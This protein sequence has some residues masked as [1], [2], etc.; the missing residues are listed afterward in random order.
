MKTP[1]IL[2]ILVV[3]LGV[4]QT[5]CDGVSTRS[6]K[7]KDYFEGE[8]QIQFVEAVAKGDETRMRELL[9]QGAD[10]NAV[11]VEEIHPLFWA[12]A[13]RSLKGF[14]FLLKNG[15]DPNYSTGNVEDKESFFSAMELAAS[16]DNSDYLLL[17][18][19][20]GGN[21]NL[22]I[23]NGTRSLINQ[24]VIYNQTE[25]VRLL[26]EA[27]ADM[28]HEDFSGKTPM[29]TAA[30]FNNYEIVYLFLEKG[31]DPTI[32]S[33]WGNDLSGQIKLIADRAM[34]FKQYKWY[35]MVVNELKSRG[36]LESNWNPIQHA[37]QEE[38]NKMR[39]Q[40]LVP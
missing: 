1:N 14:E 27:G 18:L 3:G 17:L 19:E 20:Y 33:R 21:P 9:K 12:M 37:T 24:A 7:A 28:D 23:G 30:N 36:L 26:I 16:A 8:L 2:K 11:S 15:A 25:N 10:V 6:M 34:E 4:L 38:V 35:L 40:G 29:M 39:K 32:I 13:K 22:M 5:S 31:A